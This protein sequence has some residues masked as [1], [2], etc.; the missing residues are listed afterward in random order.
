MEY[1]AAQMGGGDA[2]AE[3]P[4]PS[5]GA[6]PTRE[7]KRPP[8]PPGA[9]SPGADRASQQAAPRGKAKARAGSE[10]GRR[11]S[12]RSTPGDGA[13][14]NASEGRPP[15]PRAKA[16]ASS[17]KARVSDPAPP[18]D[19]KNV[20]K[21]PL[22]LQKRQAEAAEDKRRA[23]RPPSPTAPP[24]YRKVP[25]SE[26]QATLEVLRQRKKEAETAQR[27]LPF[28]IETQGQ[29][30]REKELTDR[31]A[32]L[33]KL[34]SMF[35]Q[36]VVFIPADAAPIA[37]S[38]PPLRD[39]GPCHAGGVQPSRP[40]ENM[41]AI[42]GGGPVSQPRGRP[43]SEAQERPSSQG[44]GSRQSSRETR[45]RVAA[46]RRA[47]CGAAAPWD[48]DNRSPVNNARTEVKV[49]QPPGG[50]SSFSLNWD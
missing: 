39:D 8:R 34:S 30:L 4:T 36:P 33:E 13:P 35:S 41:N 31:L 20:G 27:K 46:D 12:P 7:Q 44:S 40:D 32:H 50:K 1:A 42:L 18:V 17:V 14:D 23:E 45:A 10:P 25:E 43:G 11:P 9:A 5:R 49:A 16:R 28:K 37:S 19:K 21:V 2:V 3:A 26:K 48:R 47:Q 22:Y 6:T 38:V 15:A 24:G 29:K